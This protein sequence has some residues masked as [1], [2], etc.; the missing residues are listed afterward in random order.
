MLP[1]PRCVGLSHISIFWYSLEGA[2]FLARVNWCQGWKHRPEH[3]A[4]LPGT[5]RWDT[6]EEAGWADGS[7]HASLRFAR[8]VHPENLRG[9]WVVRSMP[10]PRLRPDSARTRQV[11]TDSWRLATRSDSPAVQVAA[12]ERRAN[13]DGGFI[14]RWN[15]EL[16]LRR[17][18]VSRPMASPHWL[19]HR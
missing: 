6:R 8:L 10:G 17:G 14:R 4:A 13:R 16:H 2:P 19:F 9:M 11:A 12:P 3:L 15:S 1:K 7:P 5:R 18:A